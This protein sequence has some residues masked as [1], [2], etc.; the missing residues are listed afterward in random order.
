MVSKRLQVSQVS[1]AKLH[2]ADVR[3]P[4]RT[5]SFKESLR[6][7]VSPSRPV[8]AVSPQIPFHTNPL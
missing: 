4:I 3:V 1:L 8:V 5:N 7:I 2:L 6:C